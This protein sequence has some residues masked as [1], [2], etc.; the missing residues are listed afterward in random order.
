MIKVLLTGYEAA[1]FY[2]RGGLGDVMGS[3][4]KALEK[5]D[6]EARVVVPYYQDID[7]K[8]NVP[9]VGEFS[10]VFG[11][12]LEK[13]SIHERHFPNSKV[14]IYFLGNKKYL[15]SVNIRGKNKKIDQFVFFDKA[16]VEFCYF[17]LEKKKWCPSIIHCNDW[18]TALIPLIVRGEIPT[19]LTI[20][21]LNYQGVGSRRIL[22][23]LHIKDEE[24][25]E[26]KRGRPANE[27]N[28][29][30]EGILH[31]AR[32]STVSPTYAK[33]IMID[34]EH[35]PIYSFLQ[36]REKEGLV[37]GQ[38]LGIL[39]GI[40]YD[41]WDT[42]SDHL[43][44][45]TYEADKWKAGKAENKS[46]L[47]KSL[48]LQDRPTFCF[49]GRM[50]KQKGIDLLTKSIEQIMAL[51]INIIFLGAGEPNIEKSVTRLAQKYAS[52]IRAELA[53]SEQFA[54]QLYAGADFILIPSHYEPCGLIQ[55]VAM[56]YGTIPIAAKTGGLKD[57]IDDNING[58]L[59]EKGK[60][61]SLVLTI[62]KALKTYQDQDKYEKMVN[63]AIRTDFTWDKSAFLYKNLYQEML[64]TATLPSYNMLYLSN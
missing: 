3:L 21:N 36:R 4:P 7:D 58:F 50:A 42:E 35:D 29:L 9:K 1:P 8:Y 63:M 40:D 2:K 22:D 64:S 53:Y 51:D 31:A 59:F 62:K 60:A 56:H 6:V 61:E 30:G 24:T 54:H 25:K 5:L 57:S 47:L 15:K 52:N 12:K 27:I 48:S 41:V 37:D 13:I 26:I 33:E 20:H 19:L 18:H 28:I 10:V 14:I 38:I 45:H 43:I 44:D 17:L 55:M 39:N 32:V 16:I 46:A 49:V 11:S 23:L 34:Y